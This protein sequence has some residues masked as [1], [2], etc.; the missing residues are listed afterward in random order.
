MENVFE[1]MNFAGDVFEPMNF[2]GDSSNFGAD[3][4]AIAQ[5]VGSVFSSASQMKAS[6]QASRDKALEIGGARALQLQACADNKSFKKFLDPKKRRNRINDCQKQ[7]NEKFDKKEQE[8]RDLANKQ[9]DVNK[10]ALL[11]S[12][13]N[14][15][16]DLKAKNKKNLI[17]GL[18]IGGGVL[19]LG[20][21]LFFVLRKK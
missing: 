9:L 2:D 17:I 19:I 20:T 18:S 5:G 3:Y 14:K 13:S 1:P 16:D 15:A 4:G 8:E 6:S 21:I 12:A 11:T 10:V 7:V